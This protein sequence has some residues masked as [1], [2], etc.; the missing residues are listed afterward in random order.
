MTG[1]FEIF[2]DAGMGGHVAEWII[3]AAQAAKDTFRV[4]LS[5]VS[6]L[7]ALYQFL[8]SDDFS[9]RF[10]WQGVSWYWGDGRFVPYNNPESNYRMTR[11]AIFDKAPVAP[12][13]IRNSSG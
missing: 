4:S 11:E 10:L 5:G 2:S 13:N 3:S 1:H 7:N 6:T 9:R 12:E 8:A